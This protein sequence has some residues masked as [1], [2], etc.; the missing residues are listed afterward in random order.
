MDA[1]L[2]CAIKDHREPKKIAA[3]LDISLSSINVY[4]QRIE[5]KAKKKLFLRKQNPN[6]IELNEHGLD[7]YFS[8]RQ[9][10][11]GSDGVDESLWGKGGGLEGEVKITATQT[12]LEYFYVP[13][14]TGFI[15]KYPAIDVDIRQLDDTFAIDQV[16]NEFYFT[17][18][19]KDDTSTYVYFPYHTFVQKLWASKKY[20]SVF[21]K[22]ENI[23]DLYRHNLLFQRAYLH[24]SKIFGSSQL[25]A[26][27][28]YNFNRIRAL[29]I[30]GSRIIDKLCENGLG[31]ML[32]SKETKELSAIDVEPVL[33]NFNGDA[34][35]LHVKV[36]KRI[37]TKNVARL[38]LDWLFEC[39][40]AA[41]KSINV[42]PSY[43]Y[44]NLFDLEAFEKE[45]AEDQ[46][47]KEEA[48]EP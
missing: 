28:S 38:F 43:E 26:A 8:C 15:K 19:V 23:E 24:N 36:D 34:V 5:K 35:T 3:L 6:V 37:I 7:L 33:P 42:T 46:K 2:L 1:K 39:R 27:L 4:T 30:T 11:Q 31:I 40:D 21:G 48:G 47:I 22:I 16:I 45:R 9:I 32:G 20:L 17:T 13:Y 29:K 10:G 44:K 18:E 12:I 25:K 41:L 14:L